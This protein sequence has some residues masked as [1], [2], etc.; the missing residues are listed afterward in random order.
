MTRSVEEKR[1]RFYFRHRRADGSI[2]DVEVYSGPIQIAGRCLLYSIV[3]DISDRV[4]AEAAL[5]ESEKRFRRVVE[6]APE[7]IF[8]QSEGY[9]TYVNHAALDLFGAETAEQ[10]VGTPVFVRSHPSVHELI[11]SE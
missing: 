9:W 6:G 4:A 8:I 11:R 1:N 10:L 3:H 7:A 2:R 5:K